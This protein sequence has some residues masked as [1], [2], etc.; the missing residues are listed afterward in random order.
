[1]I[2][3]ERIEN[4]VRR[5]SLTVLIAATVGALA[6]VL[7]PQQSAT[8]K[9]EPN[10]P[11]AVVPGTVLKAKECGEPATRP[12]TP[13]SIT[14][15]NVAK[16]AEVLALPRDSNN[17]PQAPPI[18]AAG[19]TQFAWDEPTLPPGSPRG[20][21][22]F[23]AHTWPDGTALGNRLLE[24]L[25]VGGKIIVKGKHGAELCYRVTKRTVIKA[26]DGSYEYYVKDGPPQLALI[27]CSPPRLGPGNWQN[28]TIWYA[29]P[30]TA[31]DPV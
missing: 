28:R 23:N 10:V 21:A 31:D 4:A 6:W 11:L 8:P 25:Q 27:V 19:K 26:A 17:V 1:M 2:S 30:I 13:K 12:F 15:R 9:T 24:H 16:N 20:N 29:S 14:V 22:L 5:G 18:S 3:R 7:W